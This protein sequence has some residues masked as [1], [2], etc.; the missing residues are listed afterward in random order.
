MPYFEE[1]DLRRYILSHRGGGVPEG[2]AA[3]QPARR[4]RVGVVQL[5]QIGVWGGMGPILG[6]P[7]N[8]AAR[9][10]A[11]RWHRKL[12]DAAA[13]LRQ[14]AA[15]GDAALRFL[16]AAVQLHHLVGEQAHGPDAGPLYVGLGSATTAEAAEAD[17]S[18]S[19][20]A[21]AAGSGLRINASPAGL[22]RERV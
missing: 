14:G 18:R 4:R 3:G 7:R 2:G 11:L 13:A 1:G 20:S 16:H 9:T 6:V 12:R 8:R 10:P 19:M 21:S 17:R 15:A 22:L 5:A